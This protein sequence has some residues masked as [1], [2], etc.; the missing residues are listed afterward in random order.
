MHRIAL[1]LFL[2]LCA[3]AQPDLAF[4]ERFA[5]DDARE[6]A[7]AELVPGT[8]DFYYYTCLHHQ[9]AGDRV[10]FAQTLETWYA[11]RRHNWSAP[12][13]ELQMR[14]HLLDFEHTPDETWK[15]LIHQLRLGFNHR[16]RSA[17]PDTDH[18]TSLSPE[19]YTLDAYL[20]RA[21]NDVGDFTTAGL[22]LAA[23]QELN[24]NERRALLSRLQ[25]SDIPNL[26]DLIVQDLATRGSRGFGQHEIHRKLTE[27]QLVDLAKKDPSVLTS[28]EYVNE[29]L[30]RLQ[31]GDE[32]D[33]QNDYAAS[34]SFYTRLYNFTRD[35]SHSHNS[36]KAL[37]LYR[38]LDA[39]RRLGTY[40]LDR[41]KAYLELP[42]SVHY[43][44]PA[45]SQ[46]WA[47]QR[48]TRVNLQLRLPTS[49]A[50]P[51]INN[52]EP[53]VR[54]LLIHFLQRQN[55]SVF[56]PYFEDSWLRKVEAEARIL[57]GETDEVWIK[58]LSP[59]EYRGLRDRIE[60]NFALQNPRQ[61]R[62]GQTVT[63]EINVKHVDKL[64]VKVFEIQAFNYYQQH[65]SA[66]DQAIDLDG[67]VA[68]HERTLTYDTPAAQRVRRTLAFPEINKR[69]V[70]VVELI[71]NGVSSRALV[72]V[73][74]LEALTVPT[75]YGQAVAVLN[76]A[77]ELVPDA[78]LWMAGS[79]YQ[80]DPSGLF[81]LPFSDA[82]KDEFI[83]LRQ[84]SFC[85][86]ERIRHLGESYTFS[87]GIYIEPQAT[88]R[89]RSSKLILRPLLQLNGI[90][91]DP[92]LLE[93]VSL[94]LRSVDADETPV[95][96]EF[97]PSFRRN[98][99]WA[100]SF[101]VPDSLRSL[102]ITVR[103]K[104]TQ[105]RD[106]TKLPLQDTFSLSL[107]S[108]RTGAALSQLLLQPTAD[109]WFAEARGINGEP[110]ANLPLRV[111]LQHPF[112]NDRI[113]AHLTT[114]DTG[115]V[116]LGPLTGLSGIQ[117][118]GGQ[119]LPA[120]LH[121]QHGSALLPATITLPAGE[122]IELPHPHPPQP[123]ATRDFSLFQLNRGKILA[124]A[125][126]SARIESGRLIID[127]LAPGSYRLRVH[128][129]QQQVD[130][131]VSDGPDRFGFAVGNLRRLQLSPSTMP[132]ITSTKADGKTL[133]IQLANADP[134]TRVLAVARRYLVD[135]PVPSPGAGVPTPAIRTVNYPFT[136]YISGRNIGDEYR[137]VLERQFAEKFAG[138]L[139]PRPG[140]ILNPWQTRE[141]Q[142][143]REVLR[144]G[145]AY[146]GHIQRKTPALARRAES[147]SS[148]FQSLDMRLGE[149]PQTLG[150]DFLPQGAILAENMIPNQDGTITLAIDELAEHTYID[151]Y[152]ADTYG[153]SRY[154]TL[155]PDRALKPRDLRLQ[156]NLPVTAHFSRQK[157]VRDI[158]ANQPVTF[159]DAASA[160]HH[161]L[162]TIGQAFDLLQTLSDDPTLDT[163]AF[164]KQWHTLPEDQKKQKLSE[165]ACHELH[166][167]LYFK[168][169]PFFDTTI[170][171]YLQHKKDKTF[172]DRWLL[173]E[174]FPAD[175]DLY[176]IRRR[177]ALEQLLWARRSGQIERVQSCFTE[178]WEM[179]PPQLDARDTWI[180]AGL[181][182]SALD[183]VTAQKQAAS[184]K[185]YDD[186]TMVLSSARRARSAA[187]A[188]PAIRAASTLDLGFARAKKSERSNMARQDAEAMPSPSAIAPP[189]ELAARAKEMAIKQNKRLYRKLP[190]TKEWA[191]QNYYQV[192][193][194]Q[195]TP[196][197]LTPTEFWRDLASGQT[198]PPS[199]IGAHR[200]LTE[201]IVALA[202]V[203]LPF[204]AKPVR[205]DR[206]QGQ[207]TLTLGNRALLISEEILPAKQSAD[208]RPLLLSQQ[209]FR[210]DDLHRFE[211]KEKIE[212][213]I[214]GEFVRRVVYGGR[215]TLTNPTASNRRLNLLLQIPQGAIPLQNGFYTKD[216][217]L[218]L[219]P[220]T[221]QRVEY[222]FYFP[223][224]GDFLQFPAQ[225]ASLEA[226]VGTAPPRTFHV[227]NAPTEVDKTSWDWISQHAATPDVLDYLRSHNIRR[228][229]LDSMAWR[230]K[231][232]DFFEQ[233]VAI[234]NDR[235]HFHETTFRYAYYHRSLA[236]ARAWLS[237]HEVA[238]RV[239][240]VLRSPLLDVDPVERAVYEHL[241][242]DPLV[243]PRA[244]QLGATHKIL[245]QA[246]RAQYRAF[247]Q[248][249]CF[250]P[251]LSPQNRLS[252]VYYQALQD[253]LPEAIAQFARI[254]R[255]ELDEKI[256]YDYM[257]AWLALRQL[258]LK[259]A[260][261]LASPHQ[262]H[263][264]KRWRT[265][266]QTLLS[267]I[268]EASGSA[269]TV[270]DQE[271]R[272]Q[273]LDAQSE[274]EPDLQLKVEAGVV[275]L[276]S[277]N[278]SSCTL[279]YYP[280]D[281]EL[282]FS[283]KPFIARDG[284]GFDVVRPSLQRQVDLQDGRSQQIQ[285]PAVLADKNMMVEA[286][287]AGLRRNQV[288]FANSLRVRLIENYG[289]VEVRS[290]AG[291][292]LP[293]TYIKVYARLTNGREEFWKDGYTDLRG[294]F[295]YVS[296]NNRN[297]NEVQSLAILVLHDRHGA[298]IREAQ[299]PKQ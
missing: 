128:A 237:Q 72:Y 294:R 205:E 66:V 85:S 232:L 261:Q 12:M 235:L 28:A 269:G 175:W 271:D 25:R 116:A 13:R 16:P 172:I 102:Q 32:V 61:F 123:G 118:S 189:V 186:D 125:N 87:A 296:L 101:F 231:E 48:L 131:L 59:A 140:L 155:L 225:A 60:L 206:N 7:L 17:K 45:L 221:T 75:P 79:E 285:L 281:I 105:Q 113:D 35:L 37:A 214:Q 8:D 233:A 50:I 180:K 49:I 57:N 63:L 141:T 152:V 163:F 132:A 39:E 297:P 256:Q 268:S 192:R 160:R 247:L 257:G 24:E 211:G 236:S 215:V 259:H 201:V 104:I 15:Y 191:E 126:S 222:S 148:G 295:D 255:A 51:P 278:L 202:L 263:P 92:A 161:V 188:S 134:A 228:L 194:S 2:S 3:I 267:S 47:K 282:L 204:E 260:K 110:V 138:S 76:E 174:N 33:L 162:G 77:G 122:S 241:E 135:G 150:Y 166:L 246:L 115:R 234:L 170:A 167:F 243:N 154:R 58:Q 176:D 290:D 265:R 44:R 19:R 185:R 250:S 179:L 114:A 40:D 107:N 83:I 97:Q 151:L 90:P 21:G 210:P 22:E 226:T 117:I 209:F 11:D 146:K 159:P 280:M 36:H 89:M 29:R 74:Q 197:R 264:I 240:R 124:S 111:H 195:N 34:V 242:Y 207:L 144:A 274:R 164:I 157:R 82:P 55:R 14:Q 223:E 52:E 200:S 108:A 262:N 120:S 64:L 42:R 31:P 273:D 216:Q 93:E 73:G 1:L 253:R 27:A 65:K 158:P 71:G 289:Q 286:T 54:D 67:M 94:T 298:L 145:E 244:H 190:S 212:K 239:G 99:E 41:F 181:G 288:Y 88:G 171:P 254:D 46:S 98:Q 127:D 139:L 81:L 193:A 84:R 249:Q 275:K 245:N 96:R 177:N 299:P 277:H 276:V 178:A 218:R 136:Q 266:F 53:L 272:Q 112:F 153:S 9:L 26:V 91:I 149:A 78:R 219:S 62:P 196:E 133:T 187:P 217:N 103:A 130:I 119:A 199:L 142:A 279:N 80:P 270:T 23:R 38:L 182:L 121:L 10:A 68:T 169:R 230:L 100:T 198:L 283:R 292:V 224:A 95:E 43:V 143:E 227:V 168:D 251:Q 106:Q 238:T 6:E 147:R 86:S 137:Y 291:Q 220:Y 229:D 258:D 208:D 213:F 70:Y 129:T 109:G 287:A 20:R 18:P 252:L 248:T 69:G 183:E 5:L 293:K 4:L 203:D 156:D 56:E 173:G 284:G 165:F 30:H 184:G